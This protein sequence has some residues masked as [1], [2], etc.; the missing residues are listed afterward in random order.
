MMIVLKFFIS[1]DLQGVFLWGV[2]GGDPSGNC[3]ES[4]MVEKVNDKIFFFFLIWVDMQNKTFLIFKKK[5]KKK[6]IIV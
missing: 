3:R 1:E 5:K 6:I 4:V 2:W